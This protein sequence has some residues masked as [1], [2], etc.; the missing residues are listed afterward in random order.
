MSG[1]SENY[2]GVFADT[3][4]MAENLLNEPLAVEDVEQSPFAA[5]RRG[6]YRS[7]GIRSL[8]SVPL[9]IHGELAGTLVFY[10]RTKHRFTSLETRVASGLGNLAAAAL[11]TAELY[12]RETELRQNAEAE[13]KKAQ[14]LARAGQVLSSSLN[15]EET[16]AT[17]VDLAVPVF[18]DWASIDIFKENDQLYRVALK[19]VD[20]A[21]IAL[22]HEFRRKYPPDA[23]DAGMAVIRT[24]KSMLVPEITDDLL[25]QGARCEDHLRMIRELGLK[26]VILVPLRTN[27]RTF[28]LLSF[29]TAESN[30]RYSEADLA[31]AEDLGRRAATAVHNAHLFS[32]SKETQEMLQRL[33]AQLQSANEDLNQFA[34]S[35]SHDLQEPLRILA[36]Y[37]QLLQRRYGEQLDERAREYLGFMVDGAKRME[38]LLRDLLAFIQTVNIAPGKLPAVRTGAALEKALANLKS[39]ILESQ[40]D[41]RYSDLPKVRVQEVHLIQL[42]QNIVGN[43]IKYRGKEKLVVEIGASQNGETC[44]IYVKDN[45]IGIAPEYQTQIFGLFKRLH[46]WD[47]YPGT[48]IGLAICQKIVERYGGRIWVESTGESGTTFRFTLPA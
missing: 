18:A 13:K 25:A 5:L 46:S 28:G 43:A 23:R 9:Q 15:Y 24:G 48:G 32:E 16:L 12:A 8:I 29:V 3:E 40:A 47:H 17:V 1:L 34:Y 44:E 35:A 39:G 11:G 7:E 30:R 14:F 26:S 33:N 45:G 2:S 42:F 10:Y 36:I 31:F 6:A 20:P 37:S 21:K 38:M 22:G 41:I 4:G 19:H 27:E